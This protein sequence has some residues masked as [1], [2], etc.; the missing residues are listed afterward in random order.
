MSY[1]DKIAEHTSHPDFVLVSEFH[2]KVYNCEDVTDEE[3]AAA[4]AAWWRCANR[5]I[6]DPSG[7]IEVFATL[8]YVLKYLPQTGDPN[9]YD[10]R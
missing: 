6:A 1:L 4:H 10:V 8:Q 9:S 3:V 2:E 7:S 5:E